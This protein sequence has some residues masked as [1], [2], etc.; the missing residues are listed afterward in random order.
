MRAGATYLP[1]A[2]AGPTLVRRSW[3]PVPG[4][5]PL[6]HTGLWR[7]VAG[8]RPGIEGDVA[9]PKSKVSLLQV[10]PSAPLAEFARDGERG[11]GR[12][13]RRGGIFGTWGGGVRRN[14]SRLPPPLGRYFP[15]YPPPKPP[16][17]GPSLTS[18]SGF[19][20]RRKEGPRSPPQLS[21]AALPDWLCVPGAQLQPLQTPSE[22]QGIRSAATQSGVGGWPRIPGLTSRGSLGGGARTGWPPQPLRG[23]A[24]RVLRPRLLSA[25]PALSFPPRGGLPPSPPPPPRPPPPPG[26]SFLPLAR[27]AAHSAAAASRGERREQ[28]PRGPL[29]A[30]ADL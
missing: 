18:W 29:A 11:Q 12:S 19:G 13:R 8:G 23:P 2:G 16:G 1:G 21:S 4:P 25:P 27:S 15:P 14:S 7:W 5:V 22:T 28:M 24:S 9:L 10:S 20:R 17:P 6:T 30:A 26:F 3:P